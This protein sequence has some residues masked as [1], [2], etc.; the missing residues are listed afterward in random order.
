MS[1][2]SIRSI[3]PIV[4]AL[5][6][7]GFTQAGRAEEDLTKAKWLPSTAYVVPKETATEG[8]GY[9]SIIEGHNG[10]LYI[11]THANGVNSWL[12][13]FDPAA[14]EMKVVVDAHKA[15]GKDIKGFGSQA[16]IHTRNNVGA[17][18]KIYFGTKQGYPDTKKGEKRE[19]Y[20]GGY[21][22][23]YDPATGETKV[24]AIPVPHEG[25]NSITPDESRGV[26]Y[27]ST[28]SDHRPG[29]G[30]NA[31]FLILDLKTGKYRNLIDTQHIYGFIVVDYLHRAY[32]PMLGGDIVR[33][34]PKTDKVERLKQTIDGKPPTAESH[35]ADK[36][37]HPINWD[38]TPDGK[39]LYSLPMSTNNAYV[40][41]LTQT[42]DTLAGKSL[43]TLIQGAKGTDCRAMCVGPSGTMW[44]DVTEAHSKVGQLQHL[45]SYN[46]SEKAPRD[47]GPV[48]VSNPN[49]TEFVG[50]DS[51]PLPFHGG[52]MKIGD[53]TT[54]KYVT[55]GVCEA[56]SGDVYILVLHPYSVL[57]VGAKELK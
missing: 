15:I 52:F 29:P 54:T 24:Y 57:K 18:G 9:F 53:V 8:E 42:G 34:D 23:V 11:G 10:R 47:H 55:M 14:E 20:L 5:I 45:V 37:G 33:Y 22:M 2:L 38:I 16:K 21:P 50:K 17:S 4:V 48:S 7:F 31:H 30:E 35:L 44:A 46:P 25:I 27:I 43:G 32:H 13:E 56:K 26:A 1:S 6:C 49:F 39:S 12:V 40:Y 41:D 28:C 3:V 36:D 51:K 19:D